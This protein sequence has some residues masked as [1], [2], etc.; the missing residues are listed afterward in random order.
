MRDGQSIEPRPLEAGTVSPSEPQPDRGW[1]SPNCPLAGEGES[2]S[3][4][5]KACR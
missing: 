3:T 4:P 1:H 2:N 5:S